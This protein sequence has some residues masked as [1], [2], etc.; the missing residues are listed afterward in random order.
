MKTPNLQHFPEDES[1]TPVERTVLNEKQREAMTQSTVR[2]EIMDAISDISPCS[3][4]ELAVELKR[5][6]QSLYYHMDILT[7]VKLV[8]Q[9]GTRKSGKR[10]EALYELASKWFRL[11]RNDDPIRANALIKMNETVIRL[12]RKNYRDAFKKNLVQEINGIENIYFRRQRGRLTDKNM[13]KVHALL[14]EIGELLEAGKQAKEGNLYSLSFF[15]SPL[16]PHQPDIDDPE[17]TA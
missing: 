3:I 14:N 4:A 12:T 1:S 13:K 11:V 15:V 2:M 5:T 6:P 9:V 8:A 16:E 7:D 10:D 17:V